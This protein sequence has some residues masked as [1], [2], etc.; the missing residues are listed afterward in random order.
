[1]ERRAADLIVDYLV[2]EGVQYALGYPGHSVMEF[3]DALYDQK[4]KIKPILVRH[5]AVASLMADGFFRAC[6]KPLVVFGHISPGATNLLTGVANAFFDSSAMIVLTG[7]A[8]TLYQGRGAY[9]EMYRFADAQL[10]E[11]FRPVV[12][13]TWQVNNAGRLPEVL[14][15]AFNTALTGRPGPVHLDIT[16]ETWPEKINLEA[17]KPDKHKPSWRI[18]GD[19]AATEKAAR[20]LAAAKRPAIIA[21]GGALISEASAELIRAAEILGAPLAT[22]IM[23]KGVVPENHPRAMGV[24]GTWGTGPANKATR[25]ADVILAIGTRFAEGDTSGWIPGATFN[26]PPTKLIHVDLEAYEIGKYYPTEVGIIGDAKSVLEDLICLLEDSKVAKA[27]TAWI[28]D[29]S[30]AKRDWEEKLAA[31]DNSQAMPINPGRVVRELRRVLP[32]DAIVVTDIGNHA[33]WI[34]Q[35]FPVYKP[36][37]YIGSMGFAAMGFGVAAALGVK[38]AKPDKKVVCVAG[39]GC[40]T[41]QPQVLA[42]AVEY[43]LPVVYCIFNDFTLGPIRYNQEK[44]YNGRMLI[45]QFKMDK[46]GEP[47][48]PDFVKMAEAYGAK[49]EVVVEPE[50]IA[51]ALDRALKAETAYVLDIRIDP[52]ER[53]LHGGGDRI[54]RFDQEVR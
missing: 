25:E 30:K 10:P 35:Q 20:L 9:Q 51:P 19:R 47:Y 50:A 52:K 40:F 11:L 34:G 38:L 17:F 33:K 53:W 48:N 14:A 39:D 54:I 6:H 21:G 26:I 49:G 8:A 31:Y 32:E 1:M 41:M 27:E 13:R 29:L 36:Q 28:D 18:R 7:E 22:T 44:Y 45:S 42:T 46:T 23:G 16:Q 15:R 37:T 2:R 5:E 3:I 24:Y 43:G 12:K 4:E